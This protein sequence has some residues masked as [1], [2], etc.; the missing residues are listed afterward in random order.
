MTNPYWATNLHLAATCI[1]EETAT[2]HSIVA[3]KLLF[4]ITRDHFM[5]VKTHFLREYLQGW[6]MPWKYL[7]KTI[8]VVKTWI[9]T[10]DVENLTLYFLPMTF[11]M[12]FLVCLPVSTA[13]LEYFCLHLVTACYW[14]WYQSVMFLYSEFNVNQCDATH[15]RQ[16][17]SWA[18]AQHVECFPSLRL[19]LFFFALLHG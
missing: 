7:P 13:F 12:A 1:K 3:K 5:F 4:T 2:L 14:V 17:Q 8:A 6:R 11:W 19:L 15:Y 9:T 18:G 16:Q 10:Y